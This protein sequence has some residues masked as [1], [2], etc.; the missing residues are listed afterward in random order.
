M[1]KKDYWGK[2]AGIRGTYLK[3]NINEHVATH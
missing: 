1:V 2:E 3:G